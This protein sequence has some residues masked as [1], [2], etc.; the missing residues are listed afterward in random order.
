[1]CYTY[2]F[3]YCIYTKLCSIMKMRRSRDMFTYVYIVQPRHRSFQFR[4]VTLITTILFILVFKQLWISVVCVQQ[5]SVAVGREVTVQIWKHGTRIAAV[6]SLPLLK[7][8]FYCGLWCGSQ[9]ISRILHCNNYT[10][11]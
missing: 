11:S 4:D 8:A 6:P 2:T 3:C 9:R 5:M 7:A 10:C 1:M